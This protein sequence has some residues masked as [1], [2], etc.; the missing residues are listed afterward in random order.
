ML[1]V[2]EEKGN[3]EKK[4]LEWKQLDEEMKSDRVKL[5]QLESIN[6]IGKTFQESTLYKILYI[7][8]VFILIILRMNSFF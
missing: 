2:E 7:K 5:Q 8:L 1:Q 3:V 6:Q 4:K